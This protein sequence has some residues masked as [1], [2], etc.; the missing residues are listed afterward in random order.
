MSII[1]QTKQL[2]ID[3]SLFKL[4]NCM[5]NIENVLIHGY[6]SRGKS[7]SPEYGT[8][9]HKFVQEYRTTGDI[10]KGIAFAMMHYSQE[11]IQAQLG[12]TDF[13][14][15]THLINTCRGYSEKYNWKSD[16]LQPAY[17][18]E[19]NLP[20]LE[21]KFKIPYKV[22][23]IRDIVYEVILAGTIDMVGF[24]SGEP[25]TVDYK[26][27]SLW[28]YD[29][30]LASYTTNSQMMF[31]K[32]IMKKLATEI[33]PETFSSFAN[34]GCIVDGIFIRKPTPGNPLC[35]IYKRSEIIRFDDSQMEDFEF[36]LNL[37]IKDLIE[38]LQTTTPWPRNFT[39]CDWGY[40]SSDNPQ[41]A[42]PFQKS[43]S[44]SDYETAKEY[45]ERDFERKEYN[46]ML[47][48]T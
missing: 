22:V 3:A 35:A 30:Y 31:Y 7:V 5:R 47:F 18:I 45:L 28:D 48:Q 15:L 37:F 44:A 24:D 38:L 1:T 17:S 12:A 20:M 21:A 46:P 19:T 10:Q 13:K 8:G 23:K 11:E 33:Y 29:S 26:S 16:T 4:H 14:T 40:K 42:C 34:V 2:Y 32:F 39:C 43:C 9:F 41:G 25:V 6:R 36:K 27:T